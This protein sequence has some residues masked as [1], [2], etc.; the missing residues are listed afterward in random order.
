M[1]ANAYGQGQRRLIVPGSNDIKLTHSG[2]YGIY[3]EYSIV[4][5]V[6]YPN[7]QMPPAIDCYLNSKST[8]R[9][10]KAVSDYVETN[11]YWSKEEGS[12]G[13]LIMSVTVNE[14]DTYTFTCRY[15]DGSKE[16][17]ITVALSPNYA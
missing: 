13:V 5:P 12:I 8:G 16:P 2:A 3:Y 9:E 10:I 6:K 17:E 1:I 11:Q 15:Q 7:G 4:G 14:P